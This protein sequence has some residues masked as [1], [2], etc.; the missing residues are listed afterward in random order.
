MPPTPLQASAR[1]WG[2]GVAKQREEQRC[3]GVFRCEHEDARACTPERACVLQLASLCECVLLSP[4]HCA[5]VRVKNPRRSMSPGTLEP[6]Q[7]SPREQICAMVCIYAN[8][9]AGHC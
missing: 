6:F 8:K 4:W 7:S 1:S 2:E 3:G 9:K 5:T